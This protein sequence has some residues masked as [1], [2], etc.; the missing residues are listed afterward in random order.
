MLALALFFAPAAP[1]QAVPVRGAEVTAASAGTDILIK[2]PRQFPVP[3]RAGETIN[4]RVEIEVPARSRSWAELTA[5]PSAMEARL[6]GSARRTSWQLPCV[7]TGDGFISW[8]AG[9]QRGCSPPGVVIR[10]GGRGPT[11]VLPTPFTGPSIA[12]AGSD[13]AQGFFSPGAFFTACS[14]TAASGGVARTATT[15]TLPGLSGVAAAP[16]CEQALADCDVAAGASGSCGVVSEVR[17]GDCTPDAVAFTQC[18]GKLTQYRGWESLILL[19]RPLFGKT[20]DCSFNVLGPDDALLLPQ[21]GLRTAVAFESN[22]RGAVISVIEGTAHVVSQQ[23]GRWVAMASGETDDSGTGEKQPTRRWL[24]A[25]NLC[26]DAL[27]DGNVETGRNQMTGALASL[28]A[29]WSASCLG[30]RTPNDGLIPY[31][32]PHPDHLDDRMHGRS[33]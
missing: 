27:D 17:P 4:D 24:A 3:L 13:L 11:A 7:F 25:S 19:L 6:V 28:A 22:K 33:R 16:P 20:L 29:R 12:A 9:G 32:K 23:S 2:R 21:E 1:A 30:N 15:F 5:I 26:Q 18:D 31:P 10:G 8:S 14:A